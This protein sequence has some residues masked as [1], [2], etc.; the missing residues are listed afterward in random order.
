MDGQRSAEPAPRPARP[1]HRTRRAIHG[2]DA[3]QPDTRTAVPAVAVADCLCIRP[4]T[5]TSTRE[6]STARAQDR[7][8]RRLLAPLL[9][10]W[11]PPT[12][13][14]RVQWVAISQ[15]REN[16]NTLVACG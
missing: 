6:R 5:R 11:T 9:N 13:H 8:S 14:F 7:R 3:A 16:Q 1:V 2:V 15:P 12:P 4:R 10:T